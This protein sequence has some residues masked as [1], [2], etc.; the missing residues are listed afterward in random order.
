M[1]IVAC[2]HIGKQTAADL[3]SYLQV[4]IVL[5]CVK[6]LL[7]DA[8]TVAIETLSW[9]EMRRL[10]ER[11]ALART[12]KQLGVKDPSAIRFAYGL[13]V[14][15]QAEKTSSTNSSTQLWHPKKSAN[16]T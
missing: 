6:N 7:R 15:T 10:N 9:M 16:T 4:H 12:V 3:N 1:D 14:E 11:L 8:W 13:V 2:N 5:Y